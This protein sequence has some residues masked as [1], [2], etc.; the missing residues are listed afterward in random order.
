MQI[1]LS[2]LTVLLVLLLLPA[3]PLTAGEPQRRVLMVGDSWAGQMWE[4][5]TVRDTFAVNGR[6]DIVEE[7]AET[8]IGGTT[9]AGWAM[10]SSLQVITDELAAYP[11]IDIVQ[12]TISGNDFLDG[13]WYV[14][15]SQ[16]NLDAF[17]AQV[18]GDLQTFFDHTLAQRPNLEIVVSL[19]DYLNLTLGCPALFDDLG[20][21]TPRQVN[22]GLVVLQTAVA[23]LVATYPRV[24]YVDHRGLMQFTFGF[25]GNG[26]SPGSIPRPGN[27]DLPSPAEAFDDCIHLNE[28]GYDTLAQNLWDSY[29]GFRFNGL[30]QDGYETGDTTAWSSTVP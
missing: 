2:V 20:Q 21:P 13:G 16:P 22:E 15:I 5:R 3:N 1:R 19:Y 8:A 9:A 27:L 6:P 23:D 4:Q 17:L 11:S 25:P 10:P 18:T 24:R 12:L 30:F 14:G 26:I 29:Y 7:G 28:A